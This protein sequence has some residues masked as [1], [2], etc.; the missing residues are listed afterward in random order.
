[1][2]NDWWKT[3]CVTA[4]RFRRG[5]LSIPGFPIRVS[6]ERR[7]HATCVNR[8]HTGEFVRL[9]NALA[10]SFPGWLSAASTARRTKRERP[11]GYLQSGRVSEIVG[12]RRRR[13]QPEERPGENR[14]G[15]GRARTWEYFPEQINPN[16]AD[17][18][19]RS[20]E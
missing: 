17:E 5:N 14:G 13:D 9:A 1:M 2:E 19:L 11:F 8:T 7:R 6:H 15:G 3:G 10:V 20:A 4:K 18:N 16:R 12:E